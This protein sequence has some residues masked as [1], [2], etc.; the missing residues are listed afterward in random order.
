MQANNY[1]NKKDFIVICLIYIIVSIDINKVIILKIEYNL[2]QI[3]SLYLYL[4]TLSFHFYLM[5]KEK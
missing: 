1:L 4:I 5:R 3:L 2:V